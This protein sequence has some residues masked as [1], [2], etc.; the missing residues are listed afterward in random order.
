[1]ADGGEFSTRA[2]LEEL[3][4]EAD[5]YGIKIIMDVVAN[6]LG[7]DPKYAPQQLQPEECWHNKGQIIHYNKREE[8][9]TGNIGMPD[10]NTENETVQQRTLAYTQDLK[11]LG[12]DG[13]RWDAAKHIGLPSEGSDFWKVVT[14]NG[15]YNYGEILNGPTDDG[16]SDD[17]MAE[18]TKYMS[19]TDDNYG[20]LLFGMFY[21]GKVT[22]KDGNWTNRGI[23]ADKLVYWGESHDNYSNDEEGLYYFEQIFVDRAYAVT[24]ARADAASLYFSRPYARAKDDIMLGEIGSKNY[25]LPHVSAVN[26]FH[27]AMIGKKDCYAASGNCAVVTREGGGAVIVCAEGSAQV[28]VENAGGYAVPGT[29]KDEVS[30]NE[31]VVTKDTITGTIGDSGIAVIYDSPFVS[32]VYTE[33]DNGKKIAAGT[34]ATLHCTEVNNASYVI[35]ETYKGSVVSEVQKE[36]SDG[37]VC[38]L[39]KDSPVNSVIKLTLSGTTDDG[40]NIS[41]EYEYT[42]CD[43][44][45]KLPQTPY[46]VRQVMFDNQQTE[47]DNVYVYAYDDNNGSKIENAAYPGQK[48][49]DVGMSYYS[50]ELPNTF[51]G[52]QDIHI[53]FSN[54]RGE[55]IKSNKCGEFII[56]LFDNLAKKKKK[57]YT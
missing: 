18:Y 4:Q 38:I 7:L 20:S 21:R 35:S 41:Q 22:D 52:C 29:Y 48:M 13:I 32:K 27:N 30:G 51:I 49:A 10:L 16:Q 2:D 46:K 11:S 34:E 45:R 23:S 43:I 40:K 26:H 37:D 54:G 17:L 15:M 6:H 47:W 33:L 24:A 28:T 36:Y 25:T 31:F 42:V 53:V 57:Y 39:G 5:K 1:M 9:T 50:C 12:V 8:I 3:C 55:E 56:D 44:D 14:N 19:V